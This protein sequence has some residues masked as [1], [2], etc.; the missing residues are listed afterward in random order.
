M[1]HSIS[2]KQQEKP[3]VKKKEFFLIAD[4]LGCLSQKLIFLRFLLYITS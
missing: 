1:Q 3:I 2:A 4:L